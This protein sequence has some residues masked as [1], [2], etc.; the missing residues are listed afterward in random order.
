MTIST[1]ENKINYV[2]DG[3]TTV[4]TFVFKVLAENHMKVYLDDVIQGTGYTVT[5]NADQNANPGGDV[6]FSVAPTTD[7]VITLLREVPIDQLVDY[8]PYD[9]FPAETHERALD[10][11]TQICQQ[12]DERVNRAITTPPSEDEGYEFPSYEARY[13]VGW[14]ETTENKLVNYPNVLDG[15]G[16][17]ANTEE[18]TATAGQT[19]FTL[20][21]PY[22]PNIGNLNVYINGVRQY[23]GSYTE[24]NSTTVTFSS[25][26]DEGDVVLFVIGEIITTVNVDAKNVSYT[27]AGTGAVPTTVQAKLR[28]SVSV[29]DFGAVGDGVADDTA[30]IQAAIDAH[31][32]STIYIPQGTYRI[33][34]TLLQNTVGLGNVSVCNFVG[35]GMTQTVID[36]QSGDAAFRVTSGAGAEF[37]YNFGLSD[38]SITS[39]TGTAGTIGIDLLGCYFVSLHRILIKDMGL[40]GIYG[41]STVGD[42]TDTAHI[43]AVHVQVQN[44]GGYGVYAKTDGNAIQY[45][46]NFYECSIG[47]CTL[48]GVLLET[49]TNTEFKSCAIYYNHGFGLKIKTGTSGAPLSKIVN[50][51]DCEFDTNEGVQIDIEAGTAITVTR[52]YLIDNNLTP[53]FTKGIV[54]G[55]ACSSIVLDQTVPRMN[56]AVTGKVVAEITAGAVDIVARDSNYAGWSVLNGSYYVDN[57]TN[58]FVIDDRSNRFNQYTG[59][60]TAEIK[61]ITLAKTS[62]TTVTAYYTVN[63]NQIMVGLRL[64]NNIDTS[65][66]AGSDIIGVTLPFPCIA[67]STAGFAGSCV[68]TNDGGTGQ[69]IPNTDNGSSLMLFIREGTGSFLIASDLTTGVSNIQVAS[70]TYIK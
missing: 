8:N 70:I 9:P 50:I 7:V 10:K 29:K 15:L 20:T 64:L 1:Y 45:G 3:S 49:I 27:P 21:T 25:G 60:Y 61:D 67:A 23:A 36:N 48:G 32:G 55:A 42:L 4:F 62:A 41:A 43:N 22:F 38:L 31:L 2:G 65:A 53:A 39:T 28:E 52:A 24:T 44:C 68:I 54:I 14:D 58:G 57:T 63:G 35:D 18:Q 13:L 37:A 17:T 69:P 59:T 46:W 11:L 30:A 26:L 6:T 40:H 51:E 56:P 5:L 19:V 33:T 47:N 66:F 16:A 12:L 34:A